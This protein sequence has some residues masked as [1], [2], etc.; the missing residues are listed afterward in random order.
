MDYRIPGVKKHHKLF[1]PEVFVD[2]ITEEV[3]PCKKAVKLEEQ[4]T[5]FVNTW[6]LG[7]EANV[8]HP[9]CD[10]NE[11]SR[12]TVQ[13]EDM[14]FGQ[15][16]TLP[17]DLVSPGIEQGD[18]AEDFQHPVFTKIQDQEG[19][20]SEEQER[21]HDS[22]DQFGPSTSFREDQ[23]AIPYHVHT[24]EKESSSELIM[25][26]VAGESTEEKIPLKEEESEDSICKENYD[27]SLVSHQILMANEASPKLRCGSVIQIPSYVPD[28]PLRCGTI[29]WIG[30]IDGIQGEIAG[31]ELVKY[32]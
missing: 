10:D 2:P 31:I 24:K 25:T 29:R 27:S 5:V 12:D 8:H 6:C 13:M 21:A 26:D 28:K 30:Q 32:T 1:L 11:A 17:H 22:F 20:S 7:E 4:P 15:Q 18:Q 23:E 19:P 3:K 9:D 14:P 16:P